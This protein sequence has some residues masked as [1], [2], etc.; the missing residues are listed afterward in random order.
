[1]SYDFPNFVVINT[2]DITSKYTVD[3]SYNQDQRELLPPKEWFTFAPE[4]FELKPG[5][6]QSVTVKL[7]IPID[8]VI[9]GNYFAYLEGKPI[10]ES[11]SGETSVGIAA[12]AKLSFTIAPSNII[13]GIYYTVKDIFIQYQPYSTVLVSAI[14]LFTLRA[15]FV[16]FF[17]FD[18][19]IKSKKKEN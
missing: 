13:E 18:F 4:I 8:D 5:E 9:P 7:K 14:A 19:N 17:S 1:M 6:S 2:G 15:I 3:I 12:A 10:A 16:K 11:D